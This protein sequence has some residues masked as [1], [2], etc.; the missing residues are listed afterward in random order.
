MIDNPILYYCL[1]ENNKPIT[2]RFINKLLKKY[3]VDY[4]ISNIDLFQEAMTHESYIVSDIKNPKTIKLLSQYKGDSI[5]RNIKDIVQLRE[6]SYERLEFLG[7]SEFHRVVSKY[8]Y[9]RYDTAKPDFLNNL[10]TNMENNKIMSKL[11]NKLGLPDYLLIAKYLENDRLNNIK[12]LADILEAFIGALSLELPYDKF[13]TFITNFIINEFDFSKMIHVQINYKETLKKHFSK[14]NFYDISYRISNINESSKS[15]KYTVIVSNGKTE[16]G[17]GS[18]P[19]AKQA[20]KLAAKNAL[21]ALKLIN[22]DDKN[23]DSDYY[24][25]NKKPKENK[26]YDIDEEEYYY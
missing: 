9:E 15:N 17:S 10:R 24:Q 8:I 13:V 12:V 19:C 6:K 16:L 14:S 11:S 18:G 26:K 3:D 5:D 4:K 21:I 22:N 7:D 2:S 23:S 1:N 20:S 25:E